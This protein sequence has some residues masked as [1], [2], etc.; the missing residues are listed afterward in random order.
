MDQIQCQRE[1]TVEREGVGEQDLTTNA[2]Q[3]NSK[4]A[5]VSHWIKVLGIP[6]LSGLDRAETGYTSLVVNQRCF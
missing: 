5:K 6:M 2:G 1:T 3:R 4:A